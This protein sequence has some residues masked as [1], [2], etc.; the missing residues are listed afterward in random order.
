MCSEGADGASLVPDAARFVDVG[1]RVQT[2]LPPSPR[3]RRRVL[4]DASIDSSA[5]HDEPSVNDRLID[6]MR[7]GDLA[8]VDL[9]AREH[10]ERLAAVARRCCR[11]PDDVADAV[12]QGLLEA[13][14]SLDSWEGRGSPLAWLGSLVA[15]SCYRMNRG[16]KNDPALHQDDDGLPCG[17]CDP[18]QAAARRQ[19]VDRV[20]AAIDGLPRP[21]RLALLL[22]LD[23]WTGPEIAEEFG[24]SPNAVRS[25]LRRARQSVRERV[26]E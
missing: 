17:R 10:G 9:M 11:R 24:C 1:R 20:A 19:E 6:L 23:G 25:R 12:Q 8:A 18:E 2:R 13:V 21:D 5:T 22:A 7:A 15:H 16:R 4:T 14:R 3:V 26:G